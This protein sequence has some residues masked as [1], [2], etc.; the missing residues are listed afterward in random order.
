MHLVP[1]V[2][3]LEVLANGVPSVQQFLENNL[4]G[5]E[6]SGSAL[7]GYRVLPTASELQEL[8]TNLLEVS[9]DWKR[10]LSP[11]LSYELVQDALIKLAREAKE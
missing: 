10:T 4:P 6:R 5:N 9:I 1:S 8:G 2:D 3:A 7:S 11:M